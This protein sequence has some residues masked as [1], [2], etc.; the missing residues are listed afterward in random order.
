MVDRG[1]KRADPMS[2]SRIV[3]VGDVVNDIVVVPRGTIR[4][5]TDTASTIRPRPGGS[6]AN[7]ATWLGS[8]GAEVDFVGS[9]GTADA[10]EHE[11]IFREYG[12]T[13][14]LDSAIG[15]PT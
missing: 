15:L 11:E 4:V 1:G 8:L 7:T 10:A 13:P 5:D 9:V 2:G 12:V 6:A 14:H 3:V